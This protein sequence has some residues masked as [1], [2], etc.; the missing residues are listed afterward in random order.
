MDNKEAQ[1]RLM[2]YLYDE[3]NAKERE[4]FEELLEKDPGLRRELHD[5][6]AT[7]KLLQ[8]EPGEIPHKNLLLIQPPSREEK[9]GTGTPSKSTNFFSLKAAAAIAA[10]ILITISVFSFANLQISHTDEGTL[11]SFGNLPE[12]ST[13]LRENY[14]R[15]EEFYTLMSELQD[16]NRRVMAAALEQTRLEH[17]EQMEEVIQ[18]LS[19]YYDR[20][21]Q[22]DLV[23]VSEGLAQLEEESYYRYLQTEEAL[24]DLIFALNIQQSEE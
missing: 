13:E 21:R 10:A 18:T 16:Q 17:Q 1:S 8:E 14:I 19:A 4:R 5:M 3:M 24:E 11:I 22:Q 15:E 20:R 9:S 7:R 6:K 23:L 12:P 2:D